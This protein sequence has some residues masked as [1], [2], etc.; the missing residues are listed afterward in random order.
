[1]QSPAGSIGEGWRGGPGRRAGS[2]GWVGAAEMRDTPTTMA[3]RRP[4]PSP[5]LAGS[6]YFSTSFLDLFL[7]FT[8]ERCPSRARV[9]GGLGRSRFG[10]IN[11]EIN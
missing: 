8:L 2:E 10:V 1:M 3:T 11:G 9:L 5:P 7:D 4:P 6:V